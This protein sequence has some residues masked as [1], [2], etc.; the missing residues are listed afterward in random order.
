MTQ[1]VYPVPA[2][3]DC[4]YLFT[5]IL[6]HALEPGEAEGIE[7]QIKAAMNT[8]GVPPGQVGVLPY[9]S[10]L[11]DW[12]PEEK[13]ESRGP[14][15][16][17]PGARYLVV[18]MVRTEEGGFTEE[19]DTVSKR[20]VRSFSQYSGLPAEHIA[21]VVLENAHLEVDWNRRNTTPAYDSRKS[22][23]RALIERLGRTE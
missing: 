5:V 1:Y 13:S 6:D 11:P 19:P 9:M 18:I 23:S 22:P 3:S 10:A 21:A 2:I 16:F 17:P 12:K 20:A 7:M 15:Y 8:L 14:E 4:H